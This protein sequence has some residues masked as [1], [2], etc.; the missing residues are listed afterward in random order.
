[1]SGPG[2][3]ATARAAGPGEIRAAGGTVKNIKLGVKITIGFGLLI[4]IACVLGGLAV[5]NMR[6]VETQSVHL[7]TEY[8]PEVVIANNIERAAL[9]TMME[10]RAY[11]LSEDKKQLEAGQRSFA[12]LKRSLGE[13]KAHS[14]KYPDLTKLRE[15]VGK[16]QARVAEYEKLIT[17]TVSRL[18]AIGGVRHT[19][20]L[21]ATE[22]VKNTAA[23]QE[24][25]NKTF[26]EE[27]AKGATA[28]V[29]RDRAGKLAGIEGV[30]A[31]ITAIR[32]NNYRGQLYRDPRHIEDAVNGFAALEQELEKLRARTSSDM[33]L[34][35]LAAIRGAAQ[36][37]RQ[38]LVGFLDNYKALQELAVKRLEA[39]NA[40]QEAAEATARAALE[41]TQHTANNAVSS[42][43]AASSVMLGGLAVALVL[44]IVVAVLLTKAVTGP[45]VKGVDFA[46]AMAEGD[47]TRLLD[48][49]QKD[50]IGILAASLNE[51]VS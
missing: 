17:E 20:D 11:G 7:A 48:V 36:N 51:M 2:R 10:M 50:E 31:Q 23:Y 35:Q 3:R 8:V 18:D 32:V 30:A 15:D 6:G 34:R 47:F 14:E 21:A 42:L 37:Y 27:I 9:Q 39:G 45:V 4:L 24:S 16:A 25:Q 26:G 49:E 1:M 44:G 46:R 5:V 43:T 33:N 38:A 12:E 29:L 40:V 41:A 13:A 28:E 19:L 22:F